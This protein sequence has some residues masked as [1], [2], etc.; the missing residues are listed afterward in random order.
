MTFNKYSKSVM[1]KPLHHRGKYCI[2][3]YFPYS[4][5]LKAHILKLKEIKWSKTHSCFYLPYGERML[6]FLISYIKEKGWDVDSFDFNKEEQKKEGE[7]Q[8]NCPTRELEPQTLQKLDQF[9][10][11]MTQKRYSENTINTYI[12]QLI[13]FFDYYKNK[14]PEDITKE[15]IEEFNYKYIIRKGYSKTYQNQTINAI[16]LYYLK[17][18]DFKHEFET[19]ERPRGSKSL[20]KVI[21]KEEVRRMLEQIANLKHKTALSLIY[22]L[23]LRR[24]ELINLELKDLDSKRRTVTIRNSKGNKDRVL[25]LPESLFKLI[26]AHYKANKP[27]KW[28][29][30]GKNPGSQYSATSLQ[31]IFKKYLAKVNKN[32]T[33]TLHSLRH[34][35]ATHLLESGTDLRYIQELLGHK[36]ART[37]EIYTYVSIKSLKNIKNPLDDFDI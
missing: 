12:S 24:S 30:E 32:A 19:L 15:D 31:N 27:K 8:F 4:N 3:L 35:Y 37:T 23:G 6:S 10:Q 7:D 16:K 36:S 29:I 28:L 25:P 9:R 1:L 34:S 20:P 13:T 17:M 21:P 14:T 18:L 33:F 11:W 5:T 26:R 2:G 22:G